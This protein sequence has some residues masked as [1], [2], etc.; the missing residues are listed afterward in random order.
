MN[1]LASRLITRICAR[2]TIRRDP[3]W[4]TQPAEPRR[5]AGL[6]T[7]AHAARAGHQRR[8]S[9]TSP[10]HATSPVRM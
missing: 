9:P 10:R 1:H 7:S 3:D 4:P 8:Q 5:R 2:C 6:V